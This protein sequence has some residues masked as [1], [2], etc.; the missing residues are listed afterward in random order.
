LLNACDVQATDTLVYSFEEGLEGFAANGAGTTVTLDTIGATDGSNSMHVSIVP[1]ATFVGANTSSL[2]PAIGD[3]PGLDHVLFDLTITEE[4]VGNFAV[5][6]VMVFGMNQTGQPRQIQTGPSILPELEYHIEDKTPGTYSD[7]F[8]DMTQFFH[9]DTFEPATFNDII[10]TPGSGPLDMIPTGFQ[11]YFNKSSDQPLSV[12]I[13]NIR[14][15]MTMAGV[16]ADYDGS[17]RVDAAD[18]V[19]WRNGGP[20]QNEVADPGTISADDYSEWVARYG[21]T[22]GSGT[23]VGGAVAVVPEPCGLSLALLAVGCLLAASKSSAARLKLSGSLADGQS[24]VVIE[25]HG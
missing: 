25:L 6:G 3:P 12:Y 4:F 8:I 10:G 23:T 15:G 1:G 7:V 20:L 2:H 22:A 11:L 19:L 18:Y 24:S 16:S 9:P 17:G 5:V 13:D 14:V 21:N